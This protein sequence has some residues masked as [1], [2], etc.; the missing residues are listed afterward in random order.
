M[1]SRVWEWRACRFML[2]AWW[3]GVD[4]WEASF[5]LHGLSSLGGSCALEAGDRFEEMQHR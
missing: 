3:E 2:L 5:L 1:R 4:L